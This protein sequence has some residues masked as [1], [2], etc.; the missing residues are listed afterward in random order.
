M[1]GGGDFVAAKIVK[2]SLKAF[3]LYEWCRIVHLK[4][5]PE[6]EFMK[7]QFRALLDYRL[8]CIVP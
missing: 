3:S 1:G 6:A 2:N 7:V 5:I 8:N 4:S